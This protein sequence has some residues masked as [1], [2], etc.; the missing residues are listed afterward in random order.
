MSNKAFPSDFSAVTPT[1]ILGDDGAAN[2]KVAVS[3]TM[4]GQFNGDAKM[5]G[6]ATKPA[7]AVVATSNLT[8]SGEQTIDGQLTAAS[9]V[10]ASA[11]SAGA[12]NGP[13]ITG[14][15]AWTR[16]TWYAAGNTIQS[17]QFITVLI[18]L[19]TTYQGS[20]WRMTTSGTIT[21]DTT[22]TV[23]VVTPHAINS[24]TI[25]GTVPTAN[26]GANLIISTIGITIDGGGVALTT[27]VKG[28]LSVPFACTIVSVTLL[29]DVSGSMVVDIWK[30]TYANYPPTVADTITASAK[31]TISSATKATDATLTGWTTA[32]AAG[33]T[34]GFNIDSCSTITRA[35]L[36]LK[37][38]RT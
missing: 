3:A 35:T 30:D 11:Q 23:W 17:F 14:A 5:L 16:P 36:V 22:A 10:L 20:T 2:G 28:Y 29:A 34:L 27:G 31:P 15:G 8:L 1:T 6:L 26:T 37:V 7:C 9:L 21:I 12:E 4:A 32:V 13:W 24:N 25:T 18:R 38:N 33:D 19:G